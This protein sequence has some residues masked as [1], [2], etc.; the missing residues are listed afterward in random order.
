[1]KSIHKYTY[2]FGTGFI[3]ISSANQFGDSIKSDIGFLIRIV[4]NQL[5]SK[6]IDSSAY[7]IKH[8]QKGFDIVVEEEMIMYL[9]FC[10][11]LE[12]N[13]G[14]TTLLREGSEIPILVNEENLTVAKLNEFT[15]SNEDLKK[16]FLINM[17]K[18]YLNENKLNDFL[19]ESNVI[20][21]STPNKT[22]KANFDVDGLDKDFVFSVNGWAYIYSIVNQN[23]EVKTKFAYNPVEVQI[24]QV[25]YI[26]QNFL[27]IFTE[28]D[29]I[30]EFN[31]MDELEV[32][33]STKNYAFIVITNND[34]VLYF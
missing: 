6:I 28:K 33:R 17:I 8:S 3:K 16:Y 2:P 31:T 18:S 20:K 11:E 10:I 15:F 26:G 25:I 32:F 24:R 19:I 30:A 7:K 21:Y 22:L 23:K 14:I 4:E 1:M 9:K 13:F 12:Q 29:E 34:E 5:N 27:Q